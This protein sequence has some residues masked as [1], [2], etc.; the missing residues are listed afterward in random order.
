MEPEPQDAGPDR[1]PPEE[2]G[3]ADAEAG[4][5]PDGIPPA[6]NAPED[7][8]AADIAAAKSAPAGDELARLRLELDEANRRVLLTQAELENFRKRTR[9]DLD[10]AL[11]YASLPLLRDIL[12]VAD[13]LQLAIQ[14]AEKHPENA[15]LLEGVQM[16]YRQ[17]GDVLRA[18]HCVEIEAAG[19]NFD[20]DLHEAIMYQPHD[21]HPEGTITQVV[22]GGYR[23]HD[24]V[25]RPPQVCVSRGQA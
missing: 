11:K 15:G 5:G 3:A 18:H 8:L 23:L 10:D 21:E 17:L 7:I 4:A 24:R 25:V 12:A 1:L 16:V 19:A 6:D 2:A 14:A 20:P 22:R 13:N 9:R